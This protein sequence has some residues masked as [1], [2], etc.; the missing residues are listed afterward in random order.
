MLLLRLLCVAAALICAAGPCPPLFAQS[1]PSRVE[2]PVLRTSI[3]VGSV[4]LTTSPL[5]RSGESY[6]GTYDARVVP[7]FFWSEHGEI[8]VTASEADLL[9]LR[10]GEEI[11]FTGQATNHRGKPRE[12]SGRA[13]P[14]G[15]DTGQIKIRIKAD[16]V[17]LI[18]NGRYQLGDE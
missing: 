6:A 14:D 12:V 10:T 11:E 13:R 3:Y 9:R 16:G 5:Q 4:R 1:A 17:E 8:A 2:V 18:F 15:V 7:W